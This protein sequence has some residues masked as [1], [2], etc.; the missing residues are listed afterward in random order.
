MMKKTEFYGKKS[1]GPRIFFLGLVLVILSALVVLAFRLDDEE[2]EWIS[3]LKQL[4][5]HSVSLDVEKAEEGFALKAISIA[6]GYL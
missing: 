3:P 4:E 2:D 1:P 6:E 5:N